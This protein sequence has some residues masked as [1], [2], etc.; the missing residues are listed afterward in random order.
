M[1]KK[2][3][4]IIGVIIAILLIII[5]LLIFLLCKDKDYKV[6]IKI[7]G[8][9]EVTDVVIKDGGILELPEDPKRDGYVFAGWIN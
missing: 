6:S 1:K 7:D 9:D 3:K 8:T 4:I 5:A 2:T